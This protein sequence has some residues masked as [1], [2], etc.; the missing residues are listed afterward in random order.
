[1]MGAARGGG[2]GAPQAMLAK[3]SGEPH[4]PHSPRSVT[5]AAGRGGHVARHVTL[6]KSFGEFPMYRVRRG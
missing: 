5:A 6:A 1:M 4:V 2:D 3:S